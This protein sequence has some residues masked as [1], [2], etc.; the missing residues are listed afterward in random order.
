MDSDELQDCLN[1][2]G[3]N[4][5]SLARQLACSKGTSWKWIGGLAAIPDEIAE[6]LRTRRKLVQALPFPRD[7][8]RPGGAGR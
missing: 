1:D 3:M 8:R 4:G 7:W 6:V 5:D 2:L